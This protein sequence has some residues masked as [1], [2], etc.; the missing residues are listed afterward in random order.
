MTITNREIEELE[1]LGEDIAWWVVSDV[2]ADLK[3]ARSLLAAILHRDNCLCTED[4]GC[5]IYRARVYLEK[6]GVRWD[7]NLAPPA[8]SDLS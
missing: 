4:T 2:L 1:G 6:A 7:T 8:A 5:P 3:E